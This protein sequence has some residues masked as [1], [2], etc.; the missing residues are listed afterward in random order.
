MGECVEAEEERV[1]YKKSATGGAALIKPSGRARHLKWDDE[2]SWG[3][4]KTPDRS[5]CVTRQNVANHDTPAQF[6][7]NPNSII[8]VEK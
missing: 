7:N 2:R 1:K 3:Q 5:T 4:L 8:R 6:E